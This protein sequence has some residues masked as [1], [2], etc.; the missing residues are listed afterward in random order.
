MEGRSQSELVRE[1]PLPARKAAEYVKTTATAMQY[2]HD[3]GVIHRDLK[4][5]N[6]LIDDFDQPRITDFGLARVIDSD[7][8]ALTAAG[9]VVG[10]PS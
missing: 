1:N 8:T 6:I 2:A 5:S 3:N 10:T 9:G 7:R 4:P